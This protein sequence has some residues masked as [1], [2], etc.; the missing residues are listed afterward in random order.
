[1]SFDDH[2]QA[3]KAL[4]TLRDAKN[5]LKKKK[6]EINELYNI[7]L[8]QNRAAL[9]LCRSVDPVRIVMNEM[10]I[11]H[12]SHDALETILREYTELDYPLLLTNKG[13]RIGCETCIDLMIKYGKTPERTI[14]TLKRRERL[15]TPGSASEKCIR[16]VQFKIFENKVLPLLLFVK[17]VPTFSRHPLY[18][19]D[20]LRSIL[21]LCK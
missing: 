2:R 16:K 14:N 10:P 21:R 7:L 3:K 19:R 13:I 11:P 20:V 5:K 6:Q 8:D 17:K 15:A 12:E 4:A 1:M 9:V 18:T